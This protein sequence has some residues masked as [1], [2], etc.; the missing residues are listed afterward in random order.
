M[1]NFVQTNNNKKV[2][3]GQIWMVDLLNG[4]KKGSVTRGYRPCVVVSND[5]GNTRSTIA[6]VVPLTSNQTKRK[7]PTHVSIKSGENNKL[8]CDSTALVEQPATVNKG[9][10][11]ICLGKISS[12]ELQEINKAIYVTFG[13]LI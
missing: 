12:E 2:L 9:Q 7:L 13:L 6:S 11:K 5:I 8:Q 1:K 4:E 3:R 10:M